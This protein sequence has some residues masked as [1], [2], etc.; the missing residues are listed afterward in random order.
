MEYSY[1]KQAINE[2]ITRENSMRAT[3][4]LNWI[5]KTTA[6]ALLLL[7]TQH[8]RADIAIGSKPFDDNPND[9]MA[10]CGKKT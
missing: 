5:L 6:S 10:I 2:S 8:A 4:N 9:L 3:T 1:F 7:L